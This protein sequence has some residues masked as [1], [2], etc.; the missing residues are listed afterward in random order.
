VL[1]LD[2][3]ALLANKHEFLEGEGFGMD[4]KIAGLVGAI[5]SIAAMTAVQAAPSP[6]VTE[7]SSARSYA[8]LLQPIPNAVA[9]LQAAKAADAERAKTETEQGSNVK[10]AWHHHH[11]HHHHRYHHHHHHHHRYHHHHHHHHHW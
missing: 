10:L 4:K 6:N 9:L 2:V 8:E 5:S 3:Y 7:V 11:H 1:L